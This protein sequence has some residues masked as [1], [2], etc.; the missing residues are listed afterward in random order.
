MRRILTLLVVLALPLAQAGASLH[1]LAHAAYAEYEVENIQCGG[2]GAPPLDHPLSKCLAFHAVD[3][4][5]S[6][7]PAAFEAPRFDAPLFSS[8]PWLFL[9][10]PRIVFDARAPPAIS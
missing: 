8:V 6:G 1:A 4:V 3:N 2:K 9:T 10:S 7:P 5:L